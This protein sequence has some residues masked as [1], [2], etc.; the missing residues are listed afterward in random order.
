MKNKKAKP[1]LLPVRPEKMAWKSFSLRGPR[2][3]NAWTRAWC[4]QFN[5][6]I[7]CLFSNLAFEKY[8]IDF[9][10]RTLNTDSEIW[11]ETLGLASRNGKS[12]GPD[13][14]LPS[15]GRARILFLIVPYQYIT[16][17]CP[18]SFNFHYF[19]FFSP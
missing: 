7:F 19:T 16:H 2:V 13:R 17:A 3:I 6:G 10:G 1:G 5:D 12:S 8:L 4:F 14:V 15:I 11:R 9:L 18:F